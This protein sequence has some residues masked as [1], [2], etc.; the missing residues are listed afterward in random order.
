MI[1]R[2]AGAVDILGC[3]ITAII[4][5]YP[6]DKLFTRDEIVFIISKTAQLIMT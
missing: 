2:E 4:D 3:L 6:Q 5:T 1:E